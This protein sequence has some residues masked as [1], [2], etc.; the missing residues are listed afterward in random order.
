MLR[1]LQPVYPPLF[2][3]CQPTWFATQSVSS[4]T[5][6]R[7]VTFPTTDTGESH[8][9]GDPV[10]L[11]REYDGLQLHGVGK[12]LLEIGEA[13]NLPTARRRPIPPN[14]AFFVFRSPSQGNTW[15]EICD[16][17]ERLLKRFTKYGWCFSLP[18]RAHSSLQSAK[19]GVLRFQEQRA[20]GGVLRQKELPITLILPGPNSSV[21]KESACSAG[22]LG[23]FPGLGR[24]PGE[25]NGNPLQYSCLENAMD[26]GAW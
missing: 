19:V 11:L 12:S 18:D 6:V 7:L 1:L 17:T 9:Q 5:Y 16:L 25:V 3:V 13:E 21:G 8:H 14:Q 15:N 26:R 22:D 10:R 24:S 2:L 20:L 4:P 23:S